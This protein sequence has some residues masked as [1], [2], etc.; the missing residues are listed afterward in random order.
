MGITDEYSFCPDIVKVRICVEDKRRVGKV[1]L[2][3]FMNV[4]NKTSLSPELFRNYHVSAV[5]PG[6]SPTLP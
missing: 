1:P 5:A 6:Y 4:G 2:F 3:A